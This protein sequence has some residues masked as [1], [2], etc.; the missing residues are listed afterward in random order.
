MYETTNNA[1]TSQTPG[2]YATT[3]QCRLKAAFEKVRNQL[4]QNFIT[5][6]LMGNLI[7]L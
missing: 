4:S 6:R 7:N 2:E 1:T 3:L 5:R